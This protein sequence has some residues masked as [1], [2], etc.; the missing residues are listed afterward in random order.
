MLGYQNRGADG[1][2]IVEQRQGGK[3]GRGGEQ[4]LVEGWRV[5][6]GVRRHQRFRAGE[7]AAFF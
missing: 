7:A 6:I 3:L 5:G 1:Q 4:A 2:R